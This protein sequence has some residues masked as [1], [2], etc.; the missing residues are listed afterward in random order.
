MDEAEPLE[1]LG[2]E[3]VQVLPAPEGERREDRV[4][5]PLSDGEEDRAVGGA[6]EDRHEDVGDET[7]RSA[8]AEVR[9]ERGAPPVREEGDVGDRGADAEERR[10]RRERGEVLPEEEDLPPHGREEEVVERLADLLAAHEAAE[11]EEA[12][13]VERPL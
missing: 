7:P 5:H 11:R 3:E 4:P 13:E 8:G 12:A 2:E 10:R 6:G 1:P 9:G